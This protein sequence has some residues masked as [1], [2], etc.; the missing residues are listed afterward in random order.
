MH[1][2]EGRRIALFG[3]HYH[4]LS[5][6]VEEVAS[7]GSQCVACVRVGFPGTREASS[8]PSKKLS[9]DAGSARTKPVAT[10]AA[11]GIRRIEPQVLGW[12][13]QAKATKCGG[14]DEEESERFIV[15]TKRGNLSQETPWRK[16]SADLWNRWR[17]R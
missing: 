7:S 11:P 12:Y 1:R 16:G 10:N 4:L 5:V 3:R 8:F 9:R 2:C 15:P 17:E 14:K 6:V 13:R